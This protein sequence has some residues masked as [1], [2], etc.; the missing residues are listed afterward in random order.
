MTFKEHFDLKKLLDYGFTKV[1]HE[2]AKM[3]DDYV[4][5]SFDFV[6][7]IGESRRG[8]FY[9]LY[10]SKEHRELYIYASN[11]DGSGSFV[12]CPDILITMVRDGLFVSTDKQLVKDITKGSKIVYGE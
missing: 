5:M 12:L 1:D 11:P 6:Y 4:A 8:Q 7:K 9:Y 10:V 2:E 3:N